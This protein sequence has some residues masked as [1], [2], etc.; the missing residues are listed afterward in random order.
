MANS[1]MVFNQLLAIGVGLI[2]GSA[3][4]GA[5]RVGLVKRVLGH[6]RRL[7]TSHEALELG[8]IDE[9][10]AD[11][12]DPKL[13][14]V[15]AVLLSIP[16]QQYRS[17]LTKFLPVLSPNC[18]IFD[19]GSTK[20]DVQLLVDELDASY[21]GLAARFVG[22]H[23]IAGGEK[24][25]PS[26]CV[27]GLF[28][29]KACVITPSDQSKPTIVAKVEKF[30]GCLGA[31]L[32][33]M[34]PIEHDEMFGAVSHLPHLLAFA[35]VN[36][37]LKHEKGREFMFEGGAGFRDF[38]RIAASSAEMWADIFQAND[39]ALLRMLD[40]FELALGELRVAIEKGDRKALDVLIG[41]ASA[42]RAEWQ[43]SGE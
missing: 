5:K 1:P 41:Q 23:P 38:T 30:W 13:R 39:S 17:V 11:P 31:N 19:A 9:V 27:N 29:G 25:G 12:S 24:H 28:A 42:F 3:C 35:Y 20:A 7:E 15:D 14:E 4:L 2:G 43:S 21:P 32:R 34:N 22:A 18:V 40:G 8:V 16:V 33:H 37:V 26:A 36:S 10:I 6:S